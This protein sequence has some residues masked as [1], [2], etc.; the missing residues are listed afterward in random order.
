M[1]RG[2]RG[3]KGMALE[4][5]QKVIAMLVADSEE[6]TVLTATE[7]GFGK[8]TLVSE[9]TRHGRGTKGMIAIQTSDRNGK[10]VAATLV[11]DADEVMLLTQKGKIVRTPVSDISVLKRATQGVTLIGLKDDSLVAV[12]RIAEEDVEEEK[13]EETQETAKAP[14][15]SEADPVQSL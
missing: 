10:V 4:D 12:Q 2:A 11:N 1:G 3:V 8:R 15:S 5:G 6:Q 14:V 13:S 9:Y 7:N